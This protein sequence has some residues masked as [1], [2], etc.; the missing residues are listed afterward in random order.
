VLSLKGKGR[1]QL[2]EEGML[3]FQR[4]K[5]ISETGRKFAQ[6]LLI[7]ELPVSSK[8]RSRFETGKGRPAAREKKGCRIRLSF[9][10][11]RSHRGEARTG[12]GEKER[13]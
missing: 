6:A 8:N 9:W 1:G 3:Q 5:E 10:S 7:I 11:S 13:R 4:R 12:R 2:I